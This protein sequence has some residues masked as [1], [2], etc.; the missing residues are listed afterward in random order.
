MADVEEAVADAFTE[1]FDRNV[2][3]SSRASARLTPSG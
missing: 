3:R 2:L 1:V